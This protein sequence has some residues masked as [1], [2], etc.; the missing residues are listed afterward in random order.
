MGSQNPGIKGRLIA[1]CIC[2]MRMP[3]LLQSTEGRVPAN[4]VNVCLRRRHKRSHI[5]QPPAGPR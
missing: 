5:N 4:P 1:G 2:I 3:D